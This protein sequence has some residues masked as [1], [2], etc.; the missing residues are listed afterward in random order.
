MAIF[1]SFEKVKKE[2]GLAVSVY[3]LSVDAAVVLFKVIGAGGIA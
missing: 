1:L 3:G 2:D